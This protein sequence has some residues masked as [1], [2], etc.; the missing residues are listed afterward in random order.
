MRGQLEIASHS[1]YA[2]AS[3]AATAVVMLFV[4]AILVGCSSTPGNFCDVAVPIRP[5][6]SDINTAS[7]QLVEDVL[8][9]NTYGARHCSWRP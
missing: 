7:D 2:V 3:R 6:A 9:H 1:L 4:L 8:A 5:A